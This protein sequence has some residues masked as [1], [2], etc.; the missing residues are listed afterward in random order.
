MKIL[1][2]I[3]GSKE[4]EKAIQACAKFLYPA[5]QIKIISVVEPRYPVASET[6]MATNEF[7]AEL[8]KNEAKNATET[9][10][11][12][13]GRLQSLF[14]NEKTEIITEILYGIPSQMI[15]EES[16]EWKADLII[17]GSH[18]YGFWQRTMIGSVSDSVIHHAQCSVLVAKSTES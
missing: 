18:G 11:K 8:E 14:D 10:R 16:E 1:L 5:E 6:F 13:A 15:V 4:S 17:V 2:A 7:Y 3:D 12:A 9:L